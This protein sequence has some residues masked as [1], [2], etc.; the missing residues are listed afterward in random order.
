[1]HNENIYFKKSK[2]EV[3]VKVLGSKWFWFGL[4]AVV[5]VVSLTA[6][7]QSVKSKYNLKCS[8]GGYFTTKEQCH[9]MAHPKPD[10]SLVPVESV[11]HKFQIIKTAKASVN[12]EAVNMESLLNAIFRQE[13][14]SGKNDSCRAKGKY[15]G[16]GYGQ[17][18]FSWL[19]FDTPEEV[20]QHVKNWIEDKQ[21]KGFTLE[22]LLCYYNEGIKKN[23]CTYATKVKSFI[24]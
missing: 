17:S 10:V 6:N 4:W 9:K 15:N 18:K 8:V 21:A 16:Y 7:Y 22:E 2:S 14:S 13:S 23:Q 3:L 19:C 12:S 24:K 11:I 1:M 5:T 20:R